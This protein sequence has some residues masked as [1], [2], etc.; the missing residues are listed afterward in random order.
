MSSLTVDG[1]DLSGTDYGLHV[2]GDFE[3]PLLGE[4]R[5]HVEPLSQADGVAIQGT[6]YD[7]MRIQIPVAIVGTSTSDAETKALNLVSFFQTRHG[8]TYYLIWS[9][10]STQR[11]TVML[12]SPINLRLAQSGATF[13]LDFQDT[14]GYPE[15]V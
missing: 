12:R 11:Y 10:R 2:M 14:T 9:E 15:T 8:S 3:V 4:P 13:M 5:V 6:T 7:A 1:T